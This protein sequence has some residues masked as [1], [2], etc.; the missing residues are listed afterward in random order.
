MKK[1]SK[2]EI[3][4]KAKAARLFALAKENNVLR[5]NAATVDDAITFIERFDFEK[6][7]FPPS[8]YHLLK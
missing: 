2:K 3:E 4:K 6:N 8:M 1:E 5:I 7:C